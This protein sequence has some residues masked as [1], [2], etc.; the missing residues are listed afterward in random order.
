MPISLD[1]SNSVR[2]FLADADEC[3][4]HG[5]QDADSSKLTDSAYSSDDYNEDVQY[6]PH[7]RLKPELVAPPPASYRP[8]RPVKTLSYDESAVYFNSNNPYRNKN[9]LDRRQY[10]IS[11]SPNMNAPHLLP[12]ASK[13]GSS[14]RSL[15]R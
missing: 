14:W 5:T 8:E 2:N 4:S 9:E 10:Q 1:T 12:S 3:I 11:R 7:N 13:I 6:E 15:M